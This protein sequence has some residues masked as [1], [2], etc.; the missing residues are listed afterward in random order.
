[1]GRTIADTAS[2][3]VS[4]GAAATSATPLPTQGGVREGL[5]ILSMMGGMSVHSSSAFSLHSPPAPSASRLREGDLSAILGSVAPSSNM[6]NTLSSRPGTNALPERTP[7]IGFLAGNSRILHHEEG[8]SVVSSDH[9]APVTVHAALSLLHLEADESCAGRSGSTRMPLPCLPPRARGSSTSS[10]TTAVVVT[11]PTYEEGQERTTPAAGSV[12]PASGASLSPP[13]PPHGDRPSNAAGGRR[14]HCFNGSSNASDLLTVLGGSASNSA[15]VGSS[16]VSPFR[17]ANRSGPRGRRSKSGAMMGSLTSLVT[18]PSTGHS[19]SAQYGVSLLMDG[20][21]MQSRCHPSSSSN[22]TPS[23][24]MLSAGSYLTDTNTWL[25]NGSSASSLSATLA[26]QTTAASARP[27]RTF[28]ASRGTGSATTASALSSRLLDA[29]PPSLQC[30]DNAAAGAARNSSSV[31]HGSA[32][33]PLQRGRRADGRHRRA[34]TYA[35]SPGLADVPTLTG[36]LSDC[37]TSLSSEDTVAAAREETVCTDVA[38]A[39]V[40]LVQSPLQQEGQQKPQH[41]QQQHQQRPAT[42]RAT[43]DTSF[44]IELV[45]ALVSPR[46]TSGTGSP[47]TMRDASA[48]RPSSSESGMPLRLVTVV[49]PSPS[50][51]SV[52]TSPVSDIPTRNAPLP[53]QQQAQ[54]PPSRDEAESEAHHRNTVRWLPGE[55]PSFRSVSGGSMRSSLLLRADPLTSRSAPVHGH[56]VAGYVAH[57]SSSPLHSPLAGDVPRSISFHSLPAARVHV[58]SA[59][60]SVDLPMDVCGT[61]TAFSSEKDKTDSPS[62]TTE[63]SLTTNASGYAGYGVECPN[64][65]SACFQQLNSF[66]RSRVSV[67]GGAAQR[68]TVGGGGG[69]SHHGSM[70][71]VNLAS[72]TNSGLARATTLVSSTTR[73]TTTHTTTTTFA[74]ADGAA[75]SSKTGIAATANPAAGGAAATTT[76]VT[77]TAVSSITCSARHIIVAQR[78]GGGAAAMVAAA[79]AS[80]LAAAID[81]PLDRSNGLMH[82]AARGDAAQSLD[83]VMVDDPDAPPFAK[84]AL[85]RFREQNPMKNGSATRRAEPRTR[86]TATSPRR[87]RTH[88]QNSVADCPVSFFV[89]TAAVQSCCTTHSFM[90][91]ARC[92]N[93]STANSPPSPQHSPPPPSSTA[94]VGRHRTSEEAEAC[95]E[96]VAKPLRANPLAVPAAARESTEP[97]TATE[98]HLPVFRQK[99]KC[100]SRKNAVRG[101]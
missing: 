70:A 100:S 10:T 74:T 27:T 34:S 65:T 44:G 29:L 1:M 99:A 12:S 4:R 28:S 56:P 9:Y 59:E 73:T 58:W 91:E 66:S 67:S 46:G 87:A 30:D 11:V 17:P 19:A 64:L 2:A 39:A 97:L 13:C 69:A 3:S 61:G 48:S 96:K 82:E 50:A 16:G 25:T 33:L 21:L 54:P 23:H 94:L 78:S 79:T 42:A 90:A 47:P 81:S 15:D 49:P 6:T 43:A 36:S 89:S 24:T 52:A 98:I 53:P 45:S 80:M 26:A 93:R 95:V 68:S 60:E 83:A 88:S 37:D 72:T 101:W 71:V 92:I 32:R 84:A 86:D 20:T 41:H 22:P 18:G 31:E 76:T 38:A 63:G 51:G 85:R 8:G 7:P 14:S 55:S 40:P 5:L 77:T 57:G 35:M 75:E 62:R